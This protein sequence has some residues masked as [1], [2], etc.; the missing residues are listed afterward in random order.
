MRLRF[1]CQ[2]MYQCSS[3]LEH[4]RRIHGDGGLADKGWRA[5]RRVIHPYH[6]RNRFEGR[7]RFR[8]TVISG[9]FF[10]SWGACG[11]VCAVIS[12]WFFP[13][14]GA[15]GRACAREKSHTFLFDELGVSC[16][17]AWKCFES[18]LPVPL[19]AWEGAQNFL[20]V[21]WAGGVKKRSP[22]CCSAAAAVRVHGGHNVLRVRLSDF[23]VNCVSESSW[24][25]PRG[26]S[27][28]SMS[29]WLLS[30]IKR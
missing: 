3:W 1:S 28:K 10:P 18:R 6:G 21:G 2:K 17:R 24:V 9:W 14:W 16:I 27:K 19:S 7:K 4:A 12:G 30:L 23:F 11:R 13:S 22:A 20:G 25:C 29:T 15:C 5:R 26:L 8:I